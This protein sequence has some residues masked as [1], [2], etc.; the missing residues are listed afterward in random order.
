MNSIEYINNRK[1]QQY[2]ISCAF[3]TVPLRMGIEECV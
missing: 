3:Q 2:S 1:F